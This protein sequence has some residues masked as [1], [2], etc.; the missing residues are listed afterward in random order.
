MFCTEGNLDLPAVK[1]PFN[2]VVV[3]QRHCTHIS[4]WPTLANVFWRA[5][6]VSKGKLQKQK[7]LEVKSI[8]NL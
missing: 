1:L 4:V 5:A 6:E 2:L 7:S 8:E 3:Y